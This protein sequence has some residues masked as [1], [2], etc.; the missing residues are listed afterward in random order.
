MLHL[1]RNKKFSFIENSNSSKEQFI[2]NFS[3]KKLKINLKSFFSIKRVMNEYDNNSKDRNDQIIF[4]S[5][6]CINY[7]A[8]IFFWS[9][10]NTKY[11]ILLIIIGCISALLAIGLIYKEHW[12][13]KLRKFFLF[14]WY[15][16]ICYC[17]PFS[18]SSLCILMN[19]TTEWIINIVIST[20]LLARLVERK[21]F[22]LLYFFGIIGGI[23]FAY[24]NTN[25]ENIYQILKIK[26]QSTSYNLL[27]AL[28]FS[29]IIS[30]I[31]F[32]RKKD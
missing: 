9:Y 4:G 22:I 29:F 18:S 12:P 23:L 11:Y 7:I 31:F 17:L 13:I 32:I 15:F 30:L 10:E 28:T 21:I 24:F 6:I 8:P 16:T 3:Y 25:W 1:L 26:D 5:F 20:I 2:I 19:G 14:Y 27:Y